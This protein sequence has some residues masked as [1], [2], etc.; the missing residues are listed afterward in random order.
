[1]QIG[2]TYVKKVPVEFSTVLFIHVGPLNRIR[3][4]VHT[5]GSN[6]INMEAMNLITLIGYWC[7]IWYLV[8]G[9][10]Q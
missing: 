1:M 6:I 3:K 7:I 2:E 8:N 4:T 9:I 5:A 10:C